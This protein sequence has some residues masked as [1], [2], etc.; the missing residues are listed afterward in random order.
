MARDAHETD[1]AVRSALSALADGE[2]TGADTAALTA[3][4]A[5]DS[6]MRREWHAWHLIG[7]ALRS[8][9]LAGRGD[10]A[11]FLDRVRARLDDEPVVIA[12]APAPAPAPTG[13]T[14]TDAAADHRRLRKRWGGGL[15]VAAGFAA[16]ATVLVALEGFPG[17][18]D[19]GT[20]LVQAPVGLRGGAV[21]VSNVAGG[22]IVTPADTTTAHG[23]ML[24]DARLDAYLSAHRQVGLGSLMG[25]AGAS[26]QQAA[27][28]NH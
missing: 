19:D 6:E 25:A 26:A 18:S 7:D 2:S 12:P 1:D 15:A 28:A 17:G 10:G 9:E 4:W 23:P 8:D 5:S 11:A 3:A 24:R 20:T 14:R 22:A 21:P 16:V 13:R 27:G